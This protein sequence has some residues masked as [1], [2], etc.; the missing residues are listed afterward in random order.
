MTNLADALDAL[1]DA[2]ADVAAA[3]F[4]DGLRVCG[5]DELLAVL[6]AAGRLRRGADAVLSEAVAEVLEREDQ[7]SHPDRV[8]VRHGCRNVGELI[9]RATRVSART[10]AEVIVTAKAA[11][12]VSPC[13]RVRCCRRSSRDY[14]T[15]WVPGRWASTV[16]SGW[17]GVPRVPGRAGR[18][19]RRRRGTR[20]GGMRGRGGCRTP[21]VGG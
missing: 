1:G 13:R 7:R 21:G 17:L 5:D 4:D 20:R 19:A 9:Q 8:T 10:A 3:V 12:D 14:A 2:L 6:A 15:R 16:W 11:V 18:T